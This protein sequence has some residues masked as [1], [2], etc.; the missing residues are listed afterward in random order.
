MNAGKGVFYRTE[1]EVKGMQGLSILSDLIIIVFNMLVYMQLVELKHDTRKNRAIMYIGCALIFAMYLAATQLLGVAVSI[2]SLICMTIPSLALFFILSK[3]KDSRFVLTF[4]FVDTITLVAGAVSRAVGLMTGDIGQIA[5]IAVLTVALGIIYFRGR[6]YF[7]RYRMLMG[8]TERGW[9]SMAIAALVIYFVLV[10]V[11]A[12]PKPLIERREYLTSYL[13]ICLMVVCHYIVTLAA[14]E[15]NYR[16]YNQSRQLKEQLHWHRVA[17]EDALTGVPNRLSFMEY[18]NDLARNEEASGIRVAMFDLDK[19]KEVND[20]FGHTYGDEI[21][22][23]AAGQLVSVFE[24]ERCRVFRI[25][26]DEFAVI[27]VDM[28]EEEMAVRLARVNSGE[29]GCSFSYGTDSALAGEHNAI[30]KA[31][32]RADAAMYAHKGAQRKE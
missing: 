29:T 5:A 23:K 21:L 31:L 18:I 7:P 3:Y 32:D 28:S 20:R 13:A 9:R 19:F 8:Y 22:K 17:H 25:G 30:E 10:F 1:K 15:K 27:A 6:R 26:G 2:A 16:F 12:Y 4:C 24:D 14:I 11:A